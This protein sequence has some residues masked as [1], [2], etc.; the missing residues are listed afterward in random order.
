[1]FGSTD[2][3]LSANTEAHASLQDVASYQNTAPALN[4]TVSQSPENAGSGIKL[5]CP[6]ADATSKNK[7][8]ARLNKQVTFNVSNETS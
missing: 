6:L 4:K 5:P 3:V 2:Y 8:S 7:S 1:M